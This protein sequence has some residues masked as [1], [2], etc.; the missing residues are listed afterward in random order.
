MNNTKPE[1]ATVEETAEAIRLLREVDLNKIMNCTLE[2]PQQ[3]LQAVEAAKSFNEGDIPLDRSRAHLVGL[4][5]SAISG[6]LIRDIIA[7]R[8][9][10]SV[11]RG[12]R[13]PHDRCGVIVS[14]YSGNT[15]EILEIAETVYGGL[16]SVVFLTSGGRLVDLSKEWCVPLWKIPTGFQ[17]RAAVGWSIG[18][19]TGVLERWRV[20]Q[21]TVDKLTKASKRLKN[22]LEQQDISEHVLIRAAEPIAEALLNRK[23]IIF[24]SL[25][26][27]G[28][29]R[30]LAAQ[31][32]ENAKQV[33]FPVVMPEAMHNVV[34]GISGSDPDSWTLIFMSDVNDQPSLRTSMLRTKTYFSETGYNCMLFPAAGDDP[35]ELTLSRLLLADFVSLFL[36]AKR[37]ID[38]TPIPAIVGLK[39]FEI[40]QDDE[41]DIEGQKDKKDSIEEAQEN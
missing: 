34:E 8:K 3:I 11:Y 38:P 18:L 20:V 1:I 23:G 35:F 39:A 9:I 29:A 6:E 41:Y 28:A 21:R 13:P 31:I 40:E 32:S 4:G 33:C 15:E 19:L 22:S 36:A 7:P 12:T 16:R 5:G 25:R 14:S 26:C 24:H 30:R 2:M 27:T 10:L 37:G 17:P